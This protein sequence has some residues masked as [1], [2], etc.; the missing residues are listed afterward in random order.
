VSIIE[1][2][3]RR[4]EQLRNAGISVPEEQEFRSP[5][6]EPTDQGETGVP[7]RGRRRIAD[8]K[9][10]A[11]TSPDAPSLSPG[12]AGAKSVQIDLERLATTGMIT[13]ESPRSKIADEFRI[14][15]RP[16][17]ANVRGAS[18]IPVARGNLIMVTSSVP[19][20]G[21]SFVSVNLA[22][23]IAM[24][25]DST[26]L[27]VDGDVIAPGVPHVLGLPPSKGLVDLLT[28]QNLDVGDVLLRTNVPRLSL[29][30]AGTANERA[31][32]LLASAA[33]IKLLDELSSRYSNRIILFDSPPLLPST[34]SRVLASK[35]GQIVMVVEADHTPQSKVKAALAT[36]ESCPV[37]QLV[38]NKVAE[39]DLGTY[40]G[41][42]YSASTPQRASLPR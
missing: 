22:M 26:V 29:L 40:Y 14:L 24:E 28:D 1:E 31:S 10:G 36:M 9:T 16:L 38:L 8:E 33:M 6:P 13:P 37:V 4:L 15:K 34:E 20:E 42:H 12:R 5:A 23:S 19:G 35:M 25:V 39:S 11:R 30:P 17:L 21:K 18:G 27:L 41:Y 32:E 3:A 2:A 7:F